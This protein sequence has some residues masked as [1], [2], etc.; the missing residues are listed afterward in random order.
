MTLG[1][2]W[3]PERALVENHYRDISLPFEPIAAPPFFVE[4]QWPLAAL[5]GYLDTWSA[6]RAM[7]RHIGRAPLEAV[8]ADLAKAWGDP[9]TLRRIRWPL[10]ILA[11]HA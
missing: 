10:T 4:A 9:E 5:I 11:G 2:Y 1:D 6:V 7:E 8:S 3:P